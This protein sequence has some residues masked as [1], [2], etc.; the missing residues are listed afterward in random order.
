MSEK[1][2]QN[3]QVGYSMKESMK[4]YRIEFII[5]V[6]SLKQNKESEHGVNLSA[7]A[8]LGVLPG[9]FLCQINDSILSLPSFG[10]R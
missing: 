8:F 4:E 5:Y 7:V 3:R 10:V 1:E 6:V 2:T 9:G